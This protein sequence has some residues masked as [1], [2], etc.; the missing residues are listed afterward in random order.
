MQ[1]ST[2][3]RTVYHT[4]LNGLI[5]CFLDWEEE[6][7]AASNNHPF[8]LLLGI[9]HSGNIYDMDLS[10]STNGIAHYCGSLSYSVSSFTVHMGADPTAAYE[11]VL[12]PYICVRQNQTLK[13]TA[14]RCC[15]TC[16]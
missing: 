15:Y 11:N 1:L 10:R 7:G 9:F 12:W 6:L 14:N 2:H 8:I 5:A 4:E 16:N 3:K 13:P